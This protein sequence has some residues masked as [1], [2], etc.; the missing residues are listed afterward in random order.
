MRVL[1]AAAHFWGYT[2]EWPRQEALQIPEEAFTACGAL[3]VGSIMLVGHVLHYNNALDNP[4]TTRASFRHRRFHYQAT[5]V[6][7]L[8]VNGTAHSVVVVPDTIAARW[9]GRA[10]FGLTTSASARC[11]SVPASCNPE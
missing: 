1:R 9:K 10:L 8:K 5:M 7:T 2:D 3:E 11:R 4:L 6:F